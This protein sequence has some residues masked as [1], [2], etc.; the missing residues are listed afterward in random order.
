MSPRSSQGKSANGAGPKKVTIRT[1]QVGFGDCFLLTFNY[2]AK[3]R[4]VLIDFGTTGTPQHN[5]DQQLLAIAQD[6]QKQCNGKL[7]AVVA[8]HRHRD[9]IRGFDKTKKYGKI[10]ASL[11]PDLVLQPWTEDPQAKTDATTATPGAN[12]NLAQSNL[13]LALDAMH[14]FSALAVEEGKS[15]SARGAGTA[16][17]VFV[18]EDNLANKPAVENLAEMGQAH[19]YVNCG[20]ATT[21]SQLLPGVKIWILGPPTLK[22]SEAIK[23]ESATNP[24]EFWQL[25]AGAQWQAQANFWSLQVETVRKHVSDQP[26]FDVR[27]TKNGKGA[28]KDSFPLETRWF[29]R[30]ANAIRGDQL[31]GLVRI[32]DD[33]MNN[34]SV[35][36][37]LEING[38]R[39]L[40]PGDAQLENWSYALKASPDQK[41]FQQLLKSV[42]LY[43]VG[44][45]GSRNATP[46][47]LWALFGANADK[48]SLTTVV[49]TMPGKFGQAAKHTE[50][51]R[52]TLI[53]ELEKHSDFH[54][55]E[56]MSKL[57]QDITLSF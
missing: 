42:E 1:Y 34:T 19:E 33:A 12:K 3:D 16:D 25:Q 17:L 5:D 28:K 2:G 55:T 38:K 6:I 43:K 18:G 21:L 26:L 46:K 23:K 32:L 7:D 35:M 44:H 22:Q 49:S 11:N 10:V 20:M 51:P 48:S 4:H 50:V 45:H 39:L 9:H 8:T 47:S 15:L 53:T 40:F 31:L 57:S 13:L 41:K 56:G 27:G 52:Q 14:Q 36:L 30:K 54:T 24:D 37:L 29:I